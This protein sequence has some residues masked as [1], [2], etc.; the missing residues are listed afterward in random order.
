MADF[1]CQLLLLLPVLLLLPMLLLLLI[2]PL[3]VS[4]WRHL[5]GKHN[6]DSSRYNLVTFKYTSKYVENGGRVS[7]IAVECSSEGN[8]HYWVSSLV[9]YVFLY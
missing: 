7:K 3:L 8:I 2:L 9:S 4:A 5:N 6:G 1:S